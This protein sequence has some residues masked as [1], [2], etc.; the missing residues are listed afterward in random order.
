MIKLRNV[1]LSA[2]AGAQLRIWQTQ[3]NGAGDYAAQVSVVDKEFSRRN[4]KNNKTFR[5]VHAALTRM[6]SGERRCCYCEDSQANQV[7]HFKPKS[8]YP[9]LVFVWSNYLY[10]CA[11]CNPPKNSR[12]AVFDAAGNPRDVTRQPNAAIMP[13]AK[14]EPVLINPRREDPTKWMQLDLLGTFRFVPTVPAGSRE[15]QRV[16]YT[17]QL[18]D[19]NRDLLPEARERAFG[20]YRARLYEYIE[21][22]DAGA[23]AKQRKPLI[24]AIR[25]MPHPT[26]WF[27]MK[28]QWR[29]IDELKTLFTKAPEALTW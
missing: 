28:R 9:E 25:T 19:L 16:E 2:T 4:R 24:E 6:C 3:I 27:E 23:S 20:D 14:G 10:A 11:I 26:V 21:K 1:R 15:F 8:L 17:I 29:K 18:L 5:E 7:E 12:F 13:P 22:R